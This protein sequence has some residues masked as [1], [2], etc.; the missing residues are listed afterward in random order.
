MM[1]GASNLHPFLALILWSSR[2]AVWLAF[3]LNLLVEAKHVAE[4]GPYYLGISWVVY[5]V[6]QRNRISV[7]SF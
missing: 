3:L 1:R 2:H 6:P 7:L 5:S 4:R